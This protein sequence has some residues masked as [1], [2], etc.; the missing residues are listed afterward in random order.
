MTSLTLDPWQV[1]SVGHLLRTPR[2][3]LG[4]E[5]RVGKT[6]P[7]I[8][9][10]LESGAAK[11]LVLCPSK[12]VTNWHREIQAW[13][14]AWSRR[15]GHSHFGV[16]WTVV[17]FDTFWRWPES[18]RAQGWDTVILDE[19]HYLRSPTAKRSQAVWGRRAGGDTPLLQSAARVWML[20]G[21][22]M[23]NDA[24]D[25]WAMFRA[26]GWTD[27]TFTQ[28]TDR[29]CYTRQTT[30]GVRAIGNKP[31]TLPELRQAF[32]S[33][34]L[35]RTFAEVHA[36][37]GEPL[38][39]RPVV[40]DLKTWPK[41]LKDLE[42]EL[43]PLY[44]ALRGES[45]DGDDPEVVSDSAA[46]LQHLTAKLMV[47]L[48]ADHVREYLEAS[49]QSKVLVLGW[50]QGPLHDLA[51]AL[52]PYRPVL[53]TGTTAN[54]D[55]VVA[56]FQTTPHVRVLIGNLMTCGTGIDLSAAS[57]VV[58]HETRW[59][60]G[61]NIQAAMRAVHRTKTAPVPVDVMGIAGSI[62]E[63]VARVRARRMQ[64]MNDVYQ[65]EG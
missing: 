2:G 61:D 39:W 60:P 3:G 37:Q 8:W 23:V 62:S 1:T 51:R 52:E 14:S 31:D 5:M 32:R 58:M 46:R 25:L 24:T 11:I 19:V 28:W 12:V 4:D 18:N 9:A 44:A 22:P 57:A 7:T 64:M 29:Y 65:P 20:S 55:A 45:S 38:L 54:P 27:L 13:S 53:L 50:H 16:G 40:L 63:A 10:A 15:T 34:F 49:T 59:T 56:A 26:M 17:S 47:P 48:T 42:D 43:A 6:A 35:R 41:E 21:T 30:W 36:G 33:R